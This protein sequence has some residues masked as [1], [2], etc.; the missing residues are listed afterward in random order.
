M[1]LDAVLTHSAALSIEKIASRIVGRRVGQA[2]I[3][4]ARLR[5]IGRFSPSTAPDFAPP[6][7]ETCVFLQE[8][9]RGSS[10]LSSTRPVCTTLHPAANPCKTGVFSCAGNSGCGPVRGKTVGCC[11]AFCSAFSRCSSAV[12]QGRI[13]RVER[14]GWGGETGVRQARRWRTPLWTSGLVFGLG[15]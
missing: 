10:P 11:S 8:D 12:T 4:E 5:S 9:V 3:R 2:S 6:S 1:V 7:P 15:P 13:S 14:R